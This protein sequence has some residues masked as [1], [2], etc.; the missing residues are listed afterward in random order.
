GP[1]AGAAA[2]PLAVG[3]VRGAGAAGARRPGGRQRGLA[4][5]L[6]SLRHVRGERARAA[7]GG[8][9]GLHHGCWPCSK[10]PPGTRPWTPARRRAG[11]ARRWRRWPRPWASRRTWTRSWPSSPRCCARG[12]AQQ[13]GRW[14]SRCACAPRTPPRCHRRAPRRPPRPPRPRRRWRGP[15]ADTSRWGWRLHALAGH[16]RAVVAQLLAVP[17]GCGPRGAGDAGGARILGRQGLPARHA[18]GRRRG[19]PEE[20]CPRAVPGACPWTKAWAGE[21]ES[22]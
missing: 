12:G 11:G 5:P 9:A 17:P 19:G 10:A 14:S 18:L 13:E 3:A 15:C 20:G 7:A 2:A 1:A 22:H 21:A 4:V 16:E 6:P 8:S